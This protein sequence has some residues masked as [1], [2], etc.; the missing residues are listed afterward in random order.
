MRY[1]KKSKYTQK[2]ESLRTASRYALVV[3]A[4]ATAFIAL[5]SKV[6]PAY[7]QKGFIFARIWL[8]PHSEGAMA[9]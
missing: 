3:C 7:S 1:Q 2:Q 4:F 5:R 8:S 6:V 9:L